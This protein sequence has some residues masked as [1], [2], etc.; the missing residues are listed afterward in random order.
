MIKEMTI[1]KMWLLIAFACLSVTVQAQMSGSG[2]ENDPYL[3]KTPDD[4]FDIRNDL[5]ACYK[6]ANDIDLTEWIAEENPTNGWAPID[7]FTG[8]FDGDGHTINGLY[9]NRKTNNVGFFGTTSNAIIKNLVIDTPNIGGNEYVGALVGNA[10]DT[11]GNLIYNIS[12]VHAVVSGKQYVGGVIGNLESPIVQN[13]SVEKA[14]VLGTGNYIGGCIGKISSDKICNCNL[15]NIIVSGINYVGGL[16]GYSKYLSYT[17]GS[18]FG[19]DIC[20]NIIIMSEISGEDYTAGLIGNVQIGKLSDILIIECDIKG[21]EHIGGIVGYLNIAYK[22]NK[23]YDVAN[24]CY[25]SGE[26]TCTSTGT[27]DNNGITGGL[28]GTIVGGRGSYLAQIVNN[29]CDININSSKRAVGLCDYF[30]NMYIQ[31]SNNIVTGNIQG[32]SEVYGIIGYAYRSEQ[33]ANVSNNVCG[34]EK[35]SSNYTRS[36]RIME[37]NSYA[38]LNNYAYNG[39]LVMQS[40]NIIDV[41]DDVCNGVGYSMRLLK[42]KNTYMGIGFDFTNEWS[43]VE[44]ETLPYSI[45]Q[46][47]PAT[48][49]KCFGGENGIV[50]GT[51]T[52]NGTVYVFVNEEM[53]TGEVTGGQWSVKLGTVNVGTTVKVSVETEGKHPSIIT[54]TVAAAP[55]EDATE[56]CATPTISFTGGKLHFDCATEGVTFHYNVVNRTTAEQTGNDNELPNTYTVTVYAT[57]DGY[58]KSEVATQEIVVSNKRGDMNGDGTISPADAVEIL[59]MFFDANNTNN[60]RPMVLDR[61]PQ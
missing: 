50:S 47:T 26:I 20:N 61:E 51:A 28:L 53:F 56:Q 24:D 9:I 4:L 38:T 59:Y 23:N 31:L 52:G 57:K 39:C 30:G 45:H 18:E 29:R 44:G 6:L 36:G 1:R 21:K 41:S 35:L 25:V 17:E 54:K 14:N 22:T 12:V 40:G 34:L 10:L 55:S 37:S 33:Y 7:N 42:R 58:N 2:T 8:T 49:E 32:K 60:A 48:I 46:S 3:V 15:T 19:I 13:I 43:I 5:S 27:S 16:S 11:K